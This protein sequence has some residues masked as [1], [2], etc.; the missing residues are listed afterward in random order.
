MFD[1]ER[2]SLH[3][4]DR[5]RA[6]EARKVITLRKEAN[7]LNVL[8]RDKPKVK[9]VTVKDGIAQEV[10]NDKLAE[11]LARGL[12]SKPIV[13][14]RRTADDDGETFHVDREA[15]LMRQKCSLNRFQA[16][17]VVA[18][19]GVT[20]KE[21]EEC[22]AEAPDE[23]YKMPDTK[24]PGEP[25]WEC[26]YED[27]PGGIWIS[28]KPIEIPHPENE[29][30]VKFFLYLEM[31]DMEDACG[32]RSMHCCIGVVPHWSEM[33]DEMKKSVR[34]CCGREQI[35]E[36]EEKLKAGDEKQALWLAESAK[37]YGACT[38]LCQAEVS[39][40]REDEDEEDEEGNSTFHRDDI[41]DDA[42]QLC[43]AKMDFDNV[44]DLMGNT[45]NGL[46]QNGWSYIFE[47]PQEFLLKQTNV[48]PT[49]ALVGKMYGME[50]VEAPIKLMEQATF[51]ACPFSIMDLSHY[52]TDPKAAM[53]AGELPCLCDNEEHRNKVMKKW[54]YKP[55][56]FEK[57]NVPVRS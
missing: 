39:W 38:S 8:H 43:R 10:P 18:R 54:G 29:R 11:D 52:K 48:T 49:Q 36:A 44:A 30:P 50:V 57:K 22:F 37:S 53:A 33:T 4:V 16:Y 15:G 25:E 41:W 7:K 2:E 24:F 19:L 27:S 47:S 42:K 1:L 56:H 45:V 20:R 31:T 28:K 13:E 17:T 5:T 21:F 51:Q 9:S 55:K 35:E 6:K 12:A 32:E 40:S 26:M 14:M 3:P 34:D 46:G 23:S